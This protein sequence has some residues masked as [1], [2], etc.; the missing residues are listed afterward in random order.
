MMQLENRLRSGLV[1]LSK[2]LLE[3]KAIIQKVQKEPKQLHIF[4]QTLFA[5]GALVSIATLI[6]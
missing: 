5:A 6:R 2:C 4:N 3:K 1:V